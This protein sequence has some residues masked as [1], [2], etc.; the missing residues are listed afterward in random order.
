MKEQLFI[1]ML[2]IAGAVFVYV[3]RRNRFSR[4]MRELKFPVISGKIISSSLREETHESENDMGHRE[5]SHTWHPEIHYA[6]EVS[7]STYQSTRYALISEP[8]FSNLEQAEKFRSRFNTGD[9]VQVHYDPA[10][11]SNAYLDDKLNE[12]TIDGKTWMVIIVLLVCA[13]AFLR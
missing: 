4:A 3:K 9:P 8:S 11:P 2:C 6:Y 1:S 13:I 12:R 5:K 7:G 10:N